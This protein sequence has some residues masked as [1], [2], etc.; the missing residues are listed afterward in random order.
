MTP[1]RQGLTALFDAL[2]V[3]HVLLVA[4]ARDL[5]QPVLAAQLARRDCMTATLTA[6]RADEL[7]RRA[8]SAACHADAPPTLLEAPP[9]AHPRPAPTLV[10][11]TKTKQQARLPAWRK[12]WLWLGGEPYWS[13]QDFFSWHRRLLQELSPYVYEVRRYRHELGSDT[14]WMYRRSLAGTIFRLL[15]LGHFGMRGLPL[16]M[17]AGMMHVLKGLLRPVQTRPVHMVRKDQSERPK[18]T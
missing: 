5:G 2:A 4:G 13:R 7:V 11:A 8:Q 9:I 14:A 3:D 12:P 6:P 1:S 18:T 17:A 15:G 16:T 10:D